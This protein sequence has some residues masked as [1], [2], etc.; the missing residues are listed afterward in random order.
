MR[1]T[2]IAWLVQAFALLHGVAPTD[3]SGVDR[4]AAQVQLEAVARELAEGIA[5]GDWTAWERHA[6]DHLLYTTE[7]GRTLTK[8]EL[9]MVFAPLPSDRRRLLTVNVV[10]ARIRGDAAFLVYELRALE[11]EGIERYRVT[12]TYWRTEGK[13]RLVASQTG[14]VA[15]D[16]DPQPAS[17]GRLSR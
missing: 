5:D 3:S 13:W 11:A 14:P 4:P 7:F 17:I 2:I 9:Q 15:E 1:E 16:V 10:G 12:D 6:S 8:K